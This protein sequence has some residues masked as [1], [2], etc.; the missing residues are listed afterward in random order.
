MVA[1]ESRRGYAAG[2]VR[3]RR[4]RGVAVCF[5]GTVNRTV[6]H[7]VVGGCWVEGSRYARY[8]ETQCLFLRCCGQD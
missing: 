7:N 1:V 5:E 3:D 6:R 8:A 2:C 4:F